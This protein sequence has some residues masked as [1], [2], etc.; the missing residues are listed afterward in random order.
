MREG[1]YFLRALS[2]I[3]VRSLRSALRELRNEAKKY[4]VFN[5][6]LLLPEP[7]KRGLTV[8]AGSCELGH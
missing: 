6:C 1:K 3:L 8:W 5:G 2:A 4:F 7:R